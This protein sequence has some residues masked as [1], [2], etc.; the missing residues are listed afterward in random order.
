MEV[1]NKWCSSC[2]NCVFTVFPDIRPSH[3]CQVD[4]GMCPVAMKVDISP[5]TV[6]VTCHT[7][8]VNRSLMRLPLKFYDGLTKRM[9][10]SAKRSPCLAIALYIGVNMCP[11]FIC[12]GRPTRV[13]CSRTRAPI[14]RRT[15]QRTTTWWGP[16][17][18]YQIQRKPSWPCGSSTWLWW[19]RIWWK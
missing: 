14:E 17:T 6:T 18:I 4:I 13:W 1:S 3:W 10:S 19:G 16:T 7:D 2:V 12:R 15:S 5:K 9:L 11:V 8:E